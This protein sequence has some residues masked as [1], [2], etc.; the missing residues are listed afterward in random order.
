[1]INVGFGRDEFG[2]LHQWDGGRETVTPT[3]TCGHCSNVVVMNSARTRERRRCLT[4]FRLI[5]EGT[6]FCRDECT[7]LPEL[8]RDHFEGPPGRQYKMVSPIMAGC[9]SY[10]EA[11]DKGLILP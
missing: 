2:E 10:E 5:C 11:K 9:T 6:P 4:C 7:P 8:A 1:M 3:Y